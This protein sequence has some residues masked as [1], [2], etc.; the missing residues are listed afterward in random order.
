MC[1]ALA[2]PITRRRAMARQR[3]EQYAWL[4]PHAIPIAKMRERRFQPAR[5]L[6][7]RKV[8]VAGVVESAY[9]GAFR[10]R[11]AF[12]SLSATPRAAFTTLSLQRRNLRDGELPTASRQFEKERRHA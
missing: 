9:S 3:N 11:P 8:S 12:L 10:R 5:C 2:A 7:Y 1:R 4:R 6:R